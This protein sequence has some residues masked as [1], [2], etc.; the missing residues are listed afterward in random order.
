ML[1]IALKT[2][3]QGTQLVPELTQILGEVQGARI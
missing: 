1:D 2:C 3:S